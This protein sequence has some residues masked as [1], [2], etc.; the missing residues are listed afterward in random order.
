MVKDLTKLKKKLSRVLGIQAPWQFSKLILDDDKARDAL[1]R[2]EPTEGSELTCPKCGAVCLGYDHRCQ[3]RH[4]DLARYKARVEADVPR[5]LCSDHGVRTVLIRWAEPKIRYTLA[6][7]VSVIE[8]LKEASISA[9]SRLLGLSWN[10]VDGIMQRAVKRGLARRQEQTVAQIGV[11]E[12]SFR[13]RHNYV[14][15]VSD[16]QSGTVLYVGEDRKISSLTD[17]YEGLSTEQLNAIKS[18]SM[19]MWPAY[20]SATK[21]HVPDAEEKIA[22]DR[23]HVAKHLGEA[24]DKVGW[25]EHKAL[26]KEGVEDL[27]GTKYEWLTA[28]DN[29]FRK[30]QISFKR[31]RS[32]TYKMARVWDLKQTASHLWHYSSRPWA[33]KGWKEW[34]AWT[35]RHRLDPITLAATRTIKNHLWGMTNAIVLNVSNGPAEGLNS[36]V[37]TIKVACRC[38]RNRQRSANAIHFHLVGRDLYSVGV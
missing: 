19:D 7:E 10:A 26:I 36:R 25:Q 33:K 1:A 27:K 20:I 34:L 5:V 6:F 2:S 18:V 32:G 28:L 12:T 24:V 17:W 22:F 29:L 8:W 11:D 37:K 4:V 35:V 3:W 23:F 31:L 30:K 15:I 9:V 16:T 21:A 13:R 14:T 38:F